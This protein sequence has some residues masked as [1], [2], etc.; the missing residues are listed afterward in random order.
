MNVCAACDKWSHECKCPPLEE[1][2]SIKLL[3]CPLCEGPPVL[4]VR[5]CITKRPFDER[6]KEY[7]RIGRYL[8]AHVFC[9]ECG[10]NSNEMDG[11]CYDA[12]DVKMLE[13]LA[14]RHWNTRNSR[15]RRLSELQERDGRNVYPESP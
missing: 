6:A 3:P 4:F 7:P 2:Q 1:G 13:L 14:V 15:H 8:S 11:D 10:C 9:H 5:D 12:D